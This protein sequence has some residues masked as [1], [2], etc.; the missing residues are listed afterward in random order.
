MPRRILQCEI[1]SRFYQ[2]YGESFIKS[3]YTHNKGWDLYVSDIG[4]SDA[5]RT[6]LQKYGTVKS[7]PVNVG[8]RWNNLTARMYT[9]QELAR[10]GN[11]VLRIDVDGVINASYDDLFKEFVESGCD[12]FGSKLVHSLARRSRSPQ[13]AAEML[14]VGL[15]HHCLHENT[16]SACFML[17]RGTPVVEQ[18]LSWIRDNW[19]RYYA[20]AKEEE[21]GLAA[22]LFK[23][24]AKYRYIDWTY[25]WSVKMSPDEFQYVIPSLT[26]VNSLGRRIHGVHFSFGKYYML[27]SVAANGNEGWRAWN[28]VVLGHYRSLPWPSA[29]DVNGTY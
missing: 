29:E 20:I 1:D 7:Y 17:L 15:D 5:E 24:G 27:S 2:L 8:H 28:D 22:V 12:V 14:G 11:I 21:P 9:L 4:L 26:P 25:F 23:L 6:Q 19:E 10:D 18:A 16:L 3:F 13:L